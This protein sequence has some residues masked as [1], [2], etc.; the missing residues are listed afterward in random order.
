[1]QVVPYFAGLSYKLLDYNAQNLQKCPKNYCWD[2]LGDEVLPVLSAHK[3]PQPHTAKRF[4]WRFFL[5]LHRKKPHQWQRW[6]QAQRAC[7]FRCQNTCTA[8]SG[9]TK[10]SACWLPAPPQPPSCYVARQQSAQAPV[11]TAVQPENTKPEMSMNV[12]LRLQFWVNNMGSCC[13]KG[14]LQQACK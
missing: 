1:M 9:W 4:L 11:L 5:P 6:A 12:L 8:A 10:P 2:T 3:S 7:G 14:T 13:T